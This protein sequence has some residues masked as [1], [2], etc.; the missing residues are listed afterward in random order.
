M[1]IRTI[2]QWCLDSIAY[3]F[4]CVTKP[5]KLAKYIRNWLKFPMIDSAARCLTEV[6][7]E[8]FSKIFP[9]DGLESDYRIS[10]SINRHSWNVR[11]D[12]EIYIYYAVQATKAKSVFE[13]GTFDGGTTAIMARAAGP[14]A[15]VFTLDLPEEE[16]DRTQHP[17][18]FTGAFVGR[19]YRETSIGAGIVQ[20]HGNSETFDFSAYYGKMDLVFVDAAHDYKHGLIDSRTALRLTHAKG[21]VLWHDFDPGWPGLVHAIIEATKGCK[22]RR[23]AGTTLAVLRK[24]E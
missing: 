10:S 1:E 9:V 12:E 21:T 24:D 6:P 23:L 19:K 3:P 17:P 20:L 18:D 5:H 15:E 8:T 22:L 2:S 4:S 14:N 13:I 7:C 16:F 11:L